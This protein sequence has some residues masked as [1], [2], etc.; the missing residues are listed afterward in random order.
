MNQV[1]S[2]EGIWSRRRSR[3]LGAHPDLHCGLCHACGEKQRVAGSGLAFCRCGLFAPEDRWGGG[4][5]GWEDEEWKPRKRNSCSLLITYWRQ[6]VFLQELRAGPFSRAVQSAL[7]RPGSGSPLAAGL[8]VTRRQV[9]PPGKMDWCG[10][11]THHR[12]QGRAVSALG[13]LRVRFLEW[14]LF[15]VR[16]RGVVSALQQRAARGGL[17]LGASVPLMWN[18]GSYLSSGGLTGQGHT[19]PRPLYLWPTPL[20]CLV[21]SQPGP[22]ILTMLA[23]PSAGHGPLW[24]GLFSGSP[25]PWLL[26]RFPGI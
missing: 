22:C 16:D 18:G 20:R 14:I 12:G 6:E 2:M 9:E 8:G 10:D 21:A 23:G 17:P 4:V 5:S 7:P 26:P 13:C 11:H 24:P 1:D 15:P 3:Y 19:L 25:S